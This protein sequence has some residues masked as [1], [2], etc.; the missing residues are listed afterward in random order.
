LFVGASLK[1]RGFTVL[2][3][4]LRI[5]KSAAGTATDIDVIVER[6][7]QSTGQIEKLYVQAKSAVSSFATG[8]HSSGVSNA[9]LFRSNPDEWLDAAKKSTRAWN[10]KVETFDPTV[11]R[12][13]SWADDATMPDELGNLIEEIAG[14]GS[15]VPIRWPGL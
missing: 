4:D 14:E 5:G 11:Q 13:W 12:I 1:K 7:N 8:Q 2:E 6:V 10:R 3:F 9:S 15:L